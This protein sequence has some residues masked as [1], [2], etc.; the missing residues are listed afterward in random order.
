MTINT[1][2]ELRNKIQ[3]LVDSHSDY[4]QEAF[5]SCDASHD[6]SEKILREYNEKV[7]RH[8]TLHIGIVGRVKAGK[9]SLL[10]SLFFE[11]KD[12]LPK[13]AT[14]MTAALTKLYYSPTLTVKINFFNK[15][16]I[17][18]LEKASSRY[19]EL[20]KIK[21]E[22]TTQSLTET[23]KKRKGEPTS[24]D[25][26]EIKEKAR[27]KTQADLESTNFLLCGE[28]EQYELYKNTD[29]SAKS[30]I[31]TNDEFNISNISEL[32]GKLSDYVGANGKYTG[33]TSNVEIGFPNEHLKEITVVDTPGFDDPVASR[34]AMA[35]D[36]LKICD[37]IFVLSPAGSF[38]NAEDKVNIAKIEKGQGIQDI[39]IIASQIDNQLCAPEYTKKNI[40]ENLSNI[41][42][43][44]N[45]TLKS[46]LAGM[47]E[48]KL[49]S[50][51]LLKKL[52]ESTDTNLLFT[53]GMCQSI[54]EQWENE[55]SWSKELK[56]IFDR[57]K[58]SYPAYFDSS[59]D[60][61]KAILAKIGNIN[62]IKSKINET[63]NQ[64]DVILQKNEEQY[65]NAKYESMKEIVNTLSESISVRKS[66]VEKG[67]IGTLEAEK[68]KMDSCYENLK[69]DF[70]DAFENEIEKYTSQIVDGLNSQVKEC[71]Q[72]R[73]S[74]INQA[75]DTDIR[76]KT[77]TV[78]VPY[79]YN[80]I[81][82][83]GSGLLNFFSFG[84]FGNH[85][86]KR[87]GIREES[88]T[89]DYTVYTINAHAVTS[90]IKDFADSVGLNLEQNAEAMK[91]KFKKALKNILLET[92]SKYDV[93][94]YCSNSARTIQANQIVNSLPDVSFSLNWEL[95]SNLSR[96]GKLEDDDARD[97]ENDAKDAMNDIRNSYLR[98]ISEYS[99]SIS[100]KLNSSAIAEEILKKMKDDIA[101]LSEQISNKQDVISK[102]EKIQEEISSLKS[103]IEK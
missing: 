42:G 20:F 99:K 69:S 78:E 3:T 48:E 58:T 64:K 50:A 9:S 21:L 14:P 82:V 67:D 94:E 93:I 92:W 100:S 47:Q 5:F 37:A 59:D 97:F 80:E 83:E 36:A 54:A 91:T 4:L 27:K 7:N 52:T 31:G 87:Q 79:T 60:S 95:P 51:A 19:H 10:N 28:A 77:Y 12:I 18:N 84:L 55:D 85:I 32:E 86:E 34:D 72:E 73:Q 22:E 63:R 43:K 96:R 68:K 30:K 102:F 75:K 65:L 2:C 57:M 49:A 71:Y 13:A 46:M 41:V 23:F 101:K 26:E 40:D 38:C 33:I 24:A 66:E 53:S 70:T 62:A 81:V 17:E 16:D 103:E 61:A 74:D 44:I 35:R 56:F 25:L 29:S 76:T 98:E 89:D 6:D 45:N 11:G 8:R 88:R 90:A 39:Y 1:I 15:T